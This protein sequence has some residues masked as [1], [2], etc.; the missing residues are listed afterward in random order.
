MSN[1]RQKHFYINICIFIAMVGVDVSFEVLVYR[2]GNTIFKV[3][4]PKIQPILRCCNF[5]LETLDT[6]K[7]IFDH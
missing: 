4:G 3:G 7:A 6:W 1:I 2:A 5:S